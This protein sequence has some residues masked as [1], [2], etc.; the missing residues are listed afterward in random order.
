MAAQPPIADQ[1]AL[2]RNFDPN[3]LAAEVI[4]DGEQWA[5]LD[6]AASVLEETRKV[7]LAK[8]TLEFL[9]AGTIGGKRVTSVAQA[10]LNAL[11]D[12]TYGQ[13]LDDMVDARKNANRARVRYDLG[14][15]R[16]E[17]LRSALATARNEM[18]I[19]GFTS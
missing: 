12:P 7:V 4:A 6:A 10:E 2:L 18:R 16:I 5:D 17:M 11:A 9:E 1:V 19:S 13:H 8:R 3:K 15:L 14:R